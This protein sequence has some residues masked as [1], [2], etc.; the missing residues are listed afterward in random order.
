LV[1]DTGQYP[2]VQEVA[3]MARCSSRTLFSHFRTLRELEVAAID[4]MLVHQVRQISATTLEL[5][6]KGRSAILVA[7]RASQ[8]E[9]WLQLWRLLLR[10]CGTQQAME[11]RMAAAREGTR[12][13]LQ[14][15]Y[16]PELSLLPDKE[17]GIALAVIEALLDFESW[18]RMRETEK[19]TYA[20]ACT[21][22][23]SAIDWVLHRK[24]SIALAV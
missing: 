10:L 24:T 8:C 16:G 23:L 20:Q 17:R 21:A 22:W 1:R 15:V 3:L 9:K 14:L 19:M 7:N 12:A 11:G 6:L 4:F 18:N 2:T 13:N 5:D